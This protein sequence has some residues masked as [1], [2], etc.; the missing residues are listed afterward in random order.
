MTKKLKHFVVNRKKMK[1]ETLFQGGIFQRRRRPTISNLLAII[2][3]TH[4]FEP[5]YSLTNRKQ[6]K[7][8]LLFFKKSNAMELSL[9]L[10]RTE[11]FN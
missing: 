2:N 5:N 3:N 11:F 10:R 6:L 8:G 4:Y 1:K 7:N 9:V